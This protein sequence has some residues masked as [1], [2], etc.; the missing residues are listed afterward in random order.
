MIIAVVLLVCFFFQ[1]KG[2]TK[3][4]SDDTFQSRSDG[5]GSGSGGLNERG[6]DKH[7]CC[8]SGNLTF[9]SIA[10]ILNNISSDNTIVNITTDAALF[11]TV[12]LEGLENI[13]I[14]GY[15]NPVLKCTDVVGA[16]KFISCRN[17]TIEGIQWKGMQGSFRHPNTISMQSI[18]L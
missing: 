13:I 12:T 6:Q 14:I 18:K 8:V 10:D 15:S 9:H 17:I 3:V 1:I 16:V 2:A 5:F 4:M 11:S 7:P